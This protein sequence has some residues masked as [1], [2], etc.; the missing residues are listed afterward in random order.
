MRLRV[1]AVMTMSVMGSMR[2][3]RMVAVR[4][5]RLLVGIMRM[6]SIG[7]LVVALLAVEDQEIH[8]KR[9][10]RRHEDARQYR[11]IGEARSPEVALVHRFDDAVLGVEAGEQGGSDQCQ[12]TE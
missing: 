7:I 8:P 4:H 2:V 6:V 10:E 1:M 12:E 11:E 9:I 3:V 5:C